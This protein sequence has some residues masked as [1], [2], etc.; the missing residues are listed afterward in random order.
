MA[1]SGPFGLEWARPLGLWALLF[2]V[3]VLIASRMRSSPPS[4]ATGTLPLWRE[5]SALA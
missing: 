1:L 2:P 4:R 5:V 3:L